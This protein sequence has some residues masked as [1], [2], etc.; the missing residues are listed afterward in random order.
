MLTKLKCNPNKPMGEVPG[1]PMD[2]TGPVG[3]MGPGGP[4]QSD[5]EF[6][7]PGSQDDV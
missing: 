4:G 3:G 5:Q 6:M 2:G 7:E 1:E